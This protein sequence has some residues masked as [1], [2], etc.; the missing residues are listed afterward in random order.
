MII[1]FVHTEGSA[2][3]E[4]GQCVT[5]K[6]VLVFFSGADHEPP[7]GF[8][9]HPKLWFS[10]ENLASASTCSLRLTLPTNHTS[11]QS[12]KESMILSLLGNDG[13]GRT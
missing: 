4:D 6:D 12:F 2:K 5:L 11:Y 10:E 13:F 8:H 1:Y 3:T 7:L 9:P